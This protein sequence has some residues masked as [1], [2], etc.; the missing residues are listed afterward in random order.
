MKFSGKEIELDKII[1]NE[2]T[3]PEK[4]KQMWYIFT[5][6]WIL[7]VKSLINNLQFI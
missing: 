3:R 5:Y 7:D 2:V 4:K 1:L 6:V